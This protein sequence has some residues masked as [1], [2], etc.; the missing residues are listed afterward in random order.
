MLTTTLVLLMIHKRM[1]TMKI[2]VKHYKLIQPNLAEHTRIWFQYVIY[3]FFVDLSVLINDLYENEVGFFLELNL[4][5][6]IWWTIILPIKLFNLSLN[7]LNSIEFLYLNNF[8]VYL[9][10]YSFIY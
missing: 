7:N 4:L 2:V 1:R 5:L 3:E 6:E 9:S 10:F 8:N